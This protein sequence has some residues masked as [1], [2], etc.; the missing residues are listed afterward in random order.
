MVSSAVVTIDSIKYLK[1][2]DAI[3][4]PRESLVARHLNTRATAAI[5]LQVAAVKSIQEIV[6][7][8]VNSPAALFVSDRIQGEKK[9]LANEVS[10]KL[11][12]LIEVSLLLYPFS[13]PHALSF[14][15]IIPYPP[16]ALQ[17][18][19]AR[20]VLRTKLSG[21]EPFFLSDD[22]PSFRF[23]MPEGL[24]D[25]DT[26][27]HRPKKPEDVNKMRKNTINR[28]KQ[29]QLDWALSQA[30]GKGKAKVKSREIIVDS[31]EEDDEDDAKSTSDED[32]APPP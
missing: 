25:L 26:Y 24:L 30:T 11:H 20:S 4:F 9:V 14:H 6:T 13:P 8:I 10:L 32:P 17:M 27:K 2:N 31:D 5:Q 29:A 18:N 19:T 15:F 16:Q 22:V 1:F 28:K 12:D 3:Y 23:S 7:K 21:I